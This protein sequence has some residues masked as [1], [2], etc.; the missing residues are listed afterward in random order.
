MRFWVKVFGFLGKYSSSMSCI[1]FKS[2]CVVLFRCLF[3]FVVFHFKRR[4]I[5]YLMFYFIRCFIYYTPFFFIRHFILCIVLFYC[6]RLFL[7]VIF[8]C[9]VL[10]R[11]F[12]TVFHDVVFYFIRHF[13]VYAVYN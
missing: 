8:L 6:I 5:L 4:F 13:I 11:H 9:V 10:L 7:Y 12:I 2:F 3:L 1:N